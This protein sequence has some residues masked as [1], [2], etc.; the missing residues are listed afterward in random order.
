MPEERPQKIQTQGAFNP[1][2]IERMLQHYDNQIR[3]L[4]SE[5]ETL[6]ARVTTLES[7]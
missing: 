1:S 4:Y 2:A 6:K 3:N 7:A 5:I